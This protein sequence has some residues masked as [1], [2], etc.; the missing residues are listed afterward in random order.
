MSSEIDAAPRDGA[1]DDPD[2]ARVPRQ[3]GPPPEGRLPDVR[4]RLGDYARGL[5]R[6]DL[7][8]VNTVVLAL[9]LIP[10]GFGFYAR[11]HW[12]AHLFAPDSRYYLTMAYR[13]MGDTVSKA[14]STQLKVSGY[15][16][17][18]WY[19]AHGDPVW[20]MVQPRMLYP[21][22]SVPFIWLFG[23]RTGMLA[24]PMLAIVVTVVAS[25]RLT[26]RLY[27]PFAALA[28]AGLLAASS[29][30][31]GLMMG[32]TDPLAMALVAL[33][34]LNLPIGRRAQGHNLV[35]LGILS[36]LLCLTRQVLPVT[37]GLAA[38][39]WLWAVL[40]PAGGGR[41]RV[42][43]EWLAP[44]AI[45]VGV[46]LAGQVIERCWRRMTPSTSSSWRTMSRRWARR[47]RTCRTWRGG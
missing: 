46:A 18:S 11:L 14:L 37:A 10:L 41:R 42:R 16:A 19:F 22:L 24:V 9:L 32:L 34:L 30:L 1:V 43:N 40:F 39:A 23:P 4:A 15:P 6:R 20:L 45:V 3:A 28:A 29:T 12:T 44:A 35:W 38:G 17:D 27:G 25:A 8:G 5:A 47:S 36:V 21:L 31:L 33:L 7:L 2:V 26:Q 13:D